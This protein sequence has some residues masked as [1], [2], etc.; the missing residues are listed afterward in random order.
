MVN[1]SGFA[2]PGLLKQ[3]SFTPSVTDISPETAEVTKQNKAHTQQSAESN[4]DDSDDEATAS[5]PAT[6]FFRCLHCEVTR[7]ARLEYSGICVYC[8]EHEQKYC[9]AGQ[10]EED[11]PCFVG[12]D[13][14]E[15]DDCNGC[16][17]AY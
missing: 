4:D 14:V 12:T 11:R 8:F 2:I 16:R 5:L 17:G 7:S 10:H 9:I 15:Y 13:G 3:P 6:S 1:S